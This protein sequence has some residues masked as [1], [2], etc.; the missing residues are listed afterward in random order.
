MIRIVIGILIGAGG[1]YAL[2]NGT[3]NIERTVKDSVHSVASEVASAT[4]PSTQDKLGEFLDS[5]TGK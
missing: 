3:E 2:L 4:E 1:A 5:L